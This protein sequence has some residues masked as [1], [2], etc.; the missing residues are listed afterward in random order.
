MYRAAPLPAKWLGREAAPVYGQ[1]I[2]MTRWATG[3]DWIDVL[4]GAPVEGAMSWPPRDPESAAMTETLMAS[5]VEVP[6]A[7]PRMSSPERW[8]WLRTVSMACAMFSMRRVSALG[9]LN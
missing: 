9:A 7:T 4:R 6:M 5:S 2:T 1:V 8:R 3:H